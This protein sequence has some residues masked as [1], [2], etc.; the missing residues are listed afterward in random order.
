[1]FPDFFYQ[2]FPKYFDDFSSLLAKEPFK[3]KETV[4]NK[5]EFKRESTPQASEQTVTSTK[6]SRAASP[7]PL[8]IGNRKRKYEAAFKEVSTDFQDVAGMEDTLKS[9]LRLMIGLKVKKAAKN[10]KRILLL[11]G[12]TGCGKTLLANAIAGQLK[13]PLLEVNATEIVS[14]V[15]GES[16][17]KLRTLFDQA[18]NA[19]HPCVLFMDEIEVIAQKKDSNR[20][21]ENRIISQLKSCMDSLKGTQV[22]F[23]A[24]TNGLDTLDLGLRSRFFEVAI[25][26]VQLLIS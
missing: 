7:T 13:W 14:G 21:M 16:E 1:M 18:T 6:T 3:E 5:K 22:L 4:T 23:I 15:S 24:A 2:L 10:L 20:G 25:G 26:N 9:L 12:P 8:K 19:G 11:H 17:A